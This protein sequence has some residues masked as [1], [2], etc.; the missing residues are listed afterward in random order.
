MPP[1]VEERHNAMWNKLTELHT[2]FRTSLEAFNGEPQLVSV[3]NEVY[4]L[5]MNAHQVQLC[6]KSTCI[7][8]QDALNI[9]AAL[10]RAMEYIWEEL[11][12]ISV[13]YNS[14]AKSHVCVRFKLIICRE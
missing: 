3:V 1:S 9:R 14:F 4:E 5:T 7:K 10:K 12:R 11:S 6:P 13:R 8:K 2:H